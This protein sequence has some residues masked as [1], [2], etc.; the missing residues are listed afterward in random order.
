MSV[1]PAVV[2]GCAAAASGIHYSQTARSTYEAGGLHTTLQIASE[3]RPYLRL[4]G[5]RFLIGGLANKQLVF[6]DGL[7]IG[8][9]QLADGLYIQYPVPGRGGDSHGRV[10]GP[11]C[12]RLRPGCMY[13]EGVAGYRAAI[14]AHWFDLISM[15][16][17]HG[18]RQDTQ[19]ERAVEHT[20]GYVLDRDRRRRPDLDLRSGVPLSD[21]TGTGR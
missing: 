16:G 11:A 20:R 8:W 9:Y 5:G 1:T 2:I 6:I 18:L 13:L 14:H 21:L 19:I 17:G 7:G 4:H 12:F 3:L 15:W 10:M